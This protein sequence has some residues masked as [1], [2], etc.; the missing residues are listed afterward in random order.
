MNTCFSVP[1]PE[2]KGTSHSVLP[3]R[4]STQRVHS[5]PVALPK[6]QSRRG[7]PDEAVD[8]FRQTVHVYNSLML[9]YALRVHRKQE[10]ATCM[11]RKEKLWSGCLCFL[12]SDVPGCKGEAHAQSRVN[13]G[14]SSNIVQRTTYPDAY[15]QMFK[16]PRK[17][18]PCSCRAC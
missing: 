5:G 1:I 6:Q 4:Q 2:S 11:G 12:V 13:P 17:H 7:T 3:R 8:S 10:R 18:L 14:I 9:P 16:R 15:T